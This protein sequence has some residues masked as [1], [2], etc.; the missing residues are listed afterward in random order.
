MTT[1]L[2]A[3]RN[4]HKVGE[5]QAILGPQFRYLTL[6]DFPGAPKVVEDAD[7][8]ASNATKKAVELAKWLTGKH[9][10][11]NFVLAD[12]SGLEVDALNGAPGVHSA[13][14][15][16][17][18]KNENSPD[19]DN[20]AKLLRLLK[21]VP[22]E[23]RTGRFRC[24]IAL[25]PVPETHVESAS[26]VCCLDEYE[27]QTFDGAC[28]GRIQIAPSGHGGF[29]YDPLFVPEGFTQ[30]FAELGEDVKNKLSHRAK[31]LAKVK[32]FFNSNETKTQRV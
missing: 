1:L 6:N 20:N 2:I 15:A 12:D 30:S 8:F 25:V 28:E 29:G 24:V 4:A 19:A 23:K 16:A 31:A 21:D 32:S 18:D 22:L 27:A 14:F 5:I 11:S 17:L 7:T 26:P 10:T 3:T 13:R 9:P